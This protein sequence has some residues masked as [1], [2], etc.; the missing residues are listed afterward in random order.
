[1]N[2]YL[3]SE[4]K[5]ENSSL[6]S[7][8][9]IINEKENKKLS[10]RL[11]E[12]QEKWLNKL[13]KYSWIANLYQLFIGLSVAYLAVWWSK[14]YLEGWIIGFA[15][16]LFVSGS[17]YGWYITRQIEIKLTDSRAAIFSYTGLMKQ[18]APML[19]ILFILRW[20]L[21]YLDTRGIEYAIPMIRTL[22][23][24]IAGVFLARSLT[25]LV[26]IFFLYRRNPVEI[27]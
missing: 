6:S 16:F 4:K 2:N 13:G 1:L 19:I 15:V 5:Q 21:R 10:S 11:T 27:T 18:F 14:P 12:L 8:K 17:A 7:Y 3:D 26:L 23:F 24:F 20:S 25:I 9:I 22:T